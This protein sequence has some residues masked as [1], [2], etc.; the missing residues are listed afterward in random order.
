M[1]SLFPSVAL[2][3]HRVLPAKKHVCDEL[4]RV[5]ARLRD[6][7]GTTTAISG[8]ALGADMLWSKTALAA[9][10]E[11]H[12]YIPFEE[13]GAR[14][15]ASDQKTWAQLRAAAS[16]EVVVGQLDGQRSTYVR[17]LH[18]RNDAMIRACDLLIAVLDLSSDSRKGGSWEAV[19]KEHRW[20]GKSRPLILIDASG[21][22]PTRMLRPGYQLPGERTA[23]GTHTGV[24]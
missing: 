21:S 8:F 19:K 1:S 14:W 3:G 13:Q 22:E 11:L 15:P 18:G 7:H 17:L 5:A 10:L 9:G 23:V 2:T 16:H 4:E 20:N 24:A 12:A 6:E